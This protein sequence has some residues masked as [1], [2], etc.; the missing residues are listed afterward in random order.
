MIFHT[1][2][3]KWDSMKFVH[4]I[5]KMYKY[6]RGNQDNF[7]IKLNIIEVL[8]SNHYN[9]CDNSYNRIN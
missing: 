4:V 6:N 8:Y 5:Y 7:K 2:A 3:E 1:S 9:R